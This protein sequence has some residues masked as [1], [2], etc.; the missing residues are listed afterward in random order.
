M[1]VEAELLMPTQYELGLNAPE[2]LGWNMGQFTQ[3]ARH[4]RQQV[5][6]SITDGQHDKHSDR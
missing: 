3:H 4:Q 6:H 2:R 5:L 1:A